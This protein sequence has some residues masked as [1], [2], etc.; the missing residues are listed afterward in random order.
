MLSIFTEP[1]K[2]EGVVLN[3]NHFE[4]FIRELLLVKQYRVEVY[5]NQGSAKNQDWI[6]EYKGSPGNLIQF[7]EILFGNNDIVANSSVIAIKLS[8][9][10]KSKVI[11]NGQ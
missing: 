2:I 11:I 8:T 9:E 6:I 4:S 1:N 7:E 5:V 10:G 3:K